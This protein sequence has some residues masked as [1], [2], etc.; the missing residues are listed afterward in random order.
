[1][2][3]GVHQTWGEWVTSQIGCV[4]FLA[5]VLPILIPLALIYRAFAFIRKALS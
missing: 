1:M 5:I 3:P 2:G 4:L